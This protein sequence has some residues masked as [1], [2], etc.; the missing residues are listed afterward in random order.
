[1]II[2]GRGPTAR[3][4]PVASSRVDAGVSARFAAGRGRA[5]ETRLRRPPH[6]AG[7]AASATAG[8][9]RRPAAR[10]LPDSGLGDRL[11]SSVWGESEN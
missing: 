8:G 2:V 3:R 9:G 7:P 10:E 11:R 6:T 5:G 1:M 4:R